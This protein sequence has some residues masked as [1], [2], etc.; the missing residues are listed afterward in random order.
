LSSTTFPQKRGRCLDYIIIGLMV[1][2]IGLFEFDRFMPV[3]AGLAREH[4]ADKTTLFS[5]ETAFEN[6]R[7]VVVLK[8]AQFALGMAQIFQL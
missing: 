8:P 2:A 4:G 6:P 5:G 1:L 7:A 3:G